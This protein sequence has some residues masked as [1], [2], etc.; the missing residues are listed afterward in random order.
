[1][2][3][4]IGI[5]SY[6]EWKNAHNS[7]QITESLE[8]WVYDKVKN[9]ETINNPNDARET[10]VY[11]GPPIQPTTWSA[12]KALQ[13]NIFSQKKFGDALD[14][15]ITPAYGNEA[16]ENAKQQVTSA[17]STSSPIIL[18]LNN[19]GIETTGV[20]QGAYFDHA[21]D[22]FAEQTGWVG[23]NDGLL[24]RDINGNGEIDNGSEL[25]GSETLLASGNKAANGFEALKALDS[26]SDHQINADDVAFAS[27]KIWIDA[28]GDGFSRASELLSLSAAG[29]SAISTI[30]SNSDVIDAQGNA[31]RQLGTYTRV[32]GT[33]AAAEDVWFTVDR[34]Y[35]VATAWVNVPDEIAG[36]PNLTGYGVVRDLQQALALDNGGSLNTLILNYKNEFDE[37]QR[38]SLVNSIIY[39]W[40]DAD[41]ISPQSRGS[42]VDARQLVALEKLLGEDFYQTGWGANPGDTAGKKIAAAYT[43]LS[44]SMFAQLEAQTQFADLYA[45]VRWNWDE[46]AQ[47]LQIDLTA[48]IAVLQT[49]LTADSVGGLALLDGFARNLK[50]LGWTD[51]SVWQSLNDGLAATEPHVVE[52]LRLAQLDTLTGNAA[53]NRLDGS[54]ADER[55]LGFSGDD[56][57]NGQGGNDVLEGGAGQ[58]T[59]EAG[60]GNDVL[61][62][63]EGND[64]LDGNS[65]SDIYSFQPGFGDDHIHQYD[66]A[67]DAVDVARFS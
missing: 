56:V 38:H 17:K 54:T 65:G 42:Y 48:V 4:D 3:Q 16:I 22:G 8:K 14:F 25:F 7:G 61:Q 19:N 20:K 33:Q 23:A 13:L 53:A 11:D 52:V 21:N 27:L 2:E 64:L 26:N 46:T 58:D 32:D 45:Q 31:H 40:T 41:S 62:G 5:K 37:G 44:N 28:N 50:A 55:L 1:M 34:T 10:R 30:Y 18:D 24:V 67:S 29:I 60:A 36:L 9:G 6:Q 57:L 35:S 51:S 47:T 63:G 12:D 39:D 15:F 49:Q 66:S 59:I 43:E